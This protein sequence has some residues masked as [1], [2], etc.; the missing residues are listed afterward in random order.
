MKVL[1][2]GINSKFIHPNLAIRYIKANSSFPIEIKE[3]TIKDP[4]EN[5]IQDIL[6]IKPDILAFSCYI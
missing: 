3:F 5:I 1:V 4:I 6:E 2:I